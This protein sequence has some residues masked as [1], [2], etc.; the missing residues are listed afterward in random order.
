VAWLVA[1]AER[2][3]KIGVVGKY[4]T[5]PDAYLSVVE[6]LRHAGFHH[7]AKIEL[8]WIHSAEQMDD[9]LAG[10]RLQQ[11]DGI[12]I[13]G[14]FGE[15]GIE[16]KV[17][18][19]GYARDH[20]IPCLGLCLGLQV[21]VIDTA[22]HLAGLE[23]ANSTE[24]D[25]ATPWPVIDLM[26]DQHD[27]VDMGGTMRLGSYVAQLVPGSQVAEAYG[28]TVVSERHRHRWEVN[29]ELRPALEKAG[30]VC[31]GVSPDGRLVEFVELPGHPFWV[32]TQAHPEFKSRPDRPH[33]LF[34]ALVAAALARAEGRL[35]RLIPID[36]DVDIG[37]VS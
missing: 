24:F 13:P 6:A 18:A 5:L 10:D 31:S 3:V 35:P 9:W 12:V 27:I 8:I 25:T 36:A 11:L 26:G 2:P 37:A 23:G 14:G 19:A 20:L 16:G 17:A 30:L 28:T 32:G 29:P 4:V 7:S 1:T 22:R 21:M 15:R 33:P 34:Q